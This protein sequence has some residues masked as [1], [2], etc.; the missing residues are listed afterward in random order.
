MVFRLSAMNALH[1]LWL[2]MAK[3]H[4]TRLAGRKALHV[5]VILAP[6]GGERSAYT[7]ADLTPVL[8]R[9]ENGWTQNT[10]SNLGQ[11]NIPPSAGNRKVVVQFLADVHSSHRGPLVQMRITF[12]GCLY[13]GPPQPRGFPE[14]AS[15]WTDVL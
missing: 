12:T 14:A 8:T 15:I 2:Q 11:N 5:L 13:Y 7:P 6:A 3:R 4:V 1:E 9:S 10:V